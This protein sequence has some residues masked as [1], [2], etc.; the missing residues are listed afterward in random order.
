MIK[1]VG[2][3]FST[4]FDDTQMKMAGEYS[5]FFSCWNDLVAKNNIPAAAAHSRIK[6]VEKGLVWI[7]VDHP[8]WKQILQT[9]KS[10][11]LSDFHYRFPKMDISGISIVLCRPENGDRGME[12][13]EQ[14]AASEDVQGV[15]AVDVQYSEYEGIK[16][17]ALKEVLMRLERRILERQQSG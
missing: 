10:K 8:G 12:D 13:M 4:L 7:E 1:R 2:E 6:T 3:I 5:A 15:S 16:D 9:K 17:P 11:L 14:R